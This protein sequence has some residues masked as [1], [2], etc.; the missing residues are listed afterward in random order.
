MRVPDK[1]LRLSTGCHF[2]LDSTHKL[3]VS[4]LR[5]IAGQV[6]DVFL[7]EVFLEEVLVR[8]NPVCSWRERKEEEEEE[9]ER[10][11]GG[12][13]RKMK[14]FASYPAWLTWI[15]VVVW[16]MFV[17]LQKLFRS[18]SQNSNSD[19]CKSEQICKLPGN[20]KQLTP[21]TNS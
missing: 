21:I 3:L 7:L 18:T 10:E 8:D 13:G 6:C 1:R 4:S 19:P 5:F 20:V 11:G 15:Y 14:Q 9:E 16:V 2:H 12:R 17:L